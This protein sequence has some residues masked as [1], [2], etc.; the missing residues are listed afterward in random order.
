[1]ITVDIKVHAICLSE[2]DGYFLEENMLEERER[3]SGDKTGCL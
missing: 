2:D 3:L 1:M